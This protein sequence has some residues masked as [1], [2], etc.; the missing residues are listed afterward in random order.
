MSDY[1]AFRGLS[2]SKEEYK[3]DYIREKNLYYLEKQKEIK[4]VKLKM[5]FLRLTLALSILI[6]L[7]LYRFLKN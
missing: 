6:I 7:A 5:V 4:R 2:E 3:R 1:D